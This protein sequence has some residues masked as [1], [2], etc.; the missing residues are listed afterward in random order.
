VFDP[1]RCAAG[2]VDL[3]LSKSS[4]I[5]AAVILRHACHRSHYIQSRFGLLL[6]GW[7]IWPIRPGTQ[8]TRAT[9]SLTGLRLFERTLSQRDFVAAET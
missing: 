6:T 2:L 7:S 5:N 8:T 9:L 3:M 4:G 1:P